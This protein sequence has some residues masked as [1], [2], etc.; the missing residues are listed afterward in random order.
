MS[1][2]FGGSDIQEVVCE[3]AALVHLGD[4]IDSALASKV[5][6]GLYKLQAAGKTDVTLLITSVGGEVGPA[7]AIADAVHDLQRQGVHVRGRVFGEAYSAAIWPL[8]ACQTRSIT[9]YSMLMVHGLTHYSSGD[10]RNL[11]AEKHANDK[12]I[13]IQAGILARRTRLSHDHWL[14]ILR[15]RVPVFYTA[16]EALHVG[17]VD[18]VDS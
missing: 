18:A 5:I 8:V 17:L 1:N 15:D 3:E 9:P 4:E 2:P 7:H 14:P 6:R 13:H 16:E 10:A 12:L 11:D